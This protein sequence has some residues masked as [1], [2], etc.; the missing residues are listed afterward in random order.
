METQLRR[1]TGNQATTSRCG[2]SSTMAVPGDTQK[3]I[4]SEGRVSG[5]ERRTRAARRTLLH[6]EAYALIRSFILGSG[7]DVV[8]A[9]HRNSFTDPRGA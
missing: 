4:H 2:R 1:V 3:F 5:K 7:D 6:D 9:W 8:L